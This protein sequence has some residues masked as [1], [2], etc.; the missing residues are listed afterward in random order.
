MCSVTLPDAARDLVEGATR[1]AVQS[2]RL[3][4]VVRG[5]IPREEWQTQAQTRCTWELTALG[6]PSEG[7]PSLAALTCEGQHNLTATAAGE[8]RRSQH[9]QRSIC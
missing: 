9:A 8:A 6:L 3:F 1:V 5:L 4:P 7:S 2:A